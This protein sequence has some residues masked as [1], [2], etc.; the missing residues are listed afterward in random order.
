MTDKPKAYATAMAF[1]RALEDRLKQIAKAEKFDFQ[2]LMREVAFDRLL[3]RLFAHEDA[4]W[5]LKGGY[6]MELRLKGARATKDLDPALRQT[7]GSSGGGKLDQ[8]ILAALRA[9]AAAELNDFFMFEVGEPMQDLDAAP[10]GG[11]RYPVEALVDGRTYVKFH[12]DIGAGDVVIAPA[13][14]LIG[15]DWLGFAGIAAVKAPAIPREQ[16]FAEKLH[17]YTLP[18]KVPNSR[19]RDLVDMVLLVNA[20]KLDEKRT[21]QAIKGTFARRGTHPVPE[22]L[23]PP[24]MAWTNPFALLAEECGLST[25]IGA[26]FAE[27]DGYFAQFTTRSRR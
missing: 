14:V 2:R 22:K 18:R 4:P 3:A 8:A 19:A 10:S 7:L 5:L 11:A 27:V 23:A 25:D 21:A 24:P 20:G 1:R 26:A 12:I 6:A 13:E 16:Q 15:R 17:A 9:A